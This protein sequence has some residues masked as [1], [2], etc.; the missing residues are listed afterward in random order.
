MC[1]SVSSHLYLQESSADVH[2]TFD[3]SNEVVP[4]H[5]SV[6]AAGSAVFARMF[7]DV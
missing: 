4:A 2:F 7:S 1:A 3:S 5:K 6:L